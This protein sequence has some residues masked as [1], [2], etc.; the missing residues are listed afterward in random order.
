MTGMD[1]T[2]TLNTDAVLLSQNNEEGAETV[3]SVKTVT[4]HVTSTTPD[5]PM[6]S[7]RVSALP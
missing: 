2:F 4:W 6:A 5:A 1:G 3:G 7:V